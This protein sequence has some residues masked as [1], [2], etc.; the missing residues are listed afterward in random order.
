MKKREPYYIEYC[1]SLI[2]DTPERIAIRFNIDLNDLLNNNP[3]L[4][5]NRVIPLSS[6]IILNGTNTI[7]KQQKRFRKRVDKCK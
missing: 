4:V 7:V 5:C 2:G 3:W 6:R 1:L